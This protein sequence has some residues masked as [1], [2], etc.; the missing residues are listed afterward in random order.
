MANKIPQAE[1]A[2]IKKKAGNINATIGVRKFWNQ[3]PHD[4]ASDR[5]TV[6]LYDDGSLSVVESAGLSVV[7]ARWGYDIFFATGAFVSAVIYRDAH[8]HYID[9][10]KVPGFP[11]PYDAGLS[12]S[13]WFRALDDIINN[14]I[15]LTIGAYTHW[16][17]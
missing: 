6:K 9:R 1:M 3:S 7:H 13:H 8:G 10:P 16:K 12:S 2:I 15:G 14:D 4:R 5:Y 11:F 17:L